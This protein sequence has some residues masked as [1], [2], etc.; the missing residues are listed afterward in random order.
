MKQFNYGS[1]DY[2]AENDIPPSTSQTMKKYV[3][4]NRSIN[5]YSAISKNRVK[6]LKSVID[7][8]NNSCVSMHSVW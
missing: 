1:N 6:N 5:Q 8:M 2:Q 4:A 7:E 3:H